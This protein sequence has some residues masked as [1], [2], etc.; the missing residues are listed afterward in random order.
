MR[1]HR[2]PN[3]DRASERARWRQAPGCCIWLTWKS[4]VSFIPTVMLHVGLRWPVSV[5]IFHENAGVFSSNHL[6]LLHCPPTLPNTFMVKKPRKAMPFP[7]FCDLLGK[8]FFLLAGICF[9]RPDACEG[10][11]HKRHWVSFSILAIP[12]YEM[13]LS[14]LMGRSMLIRVATSMVVMARS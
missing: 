11:E 3:S 7:A 5:E 4:E 12:G 14:S 6:D 2:T 10:L 9:P 8:S 13:P 1:L